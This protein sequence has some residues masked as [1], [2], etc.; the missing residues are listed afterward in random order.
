MALSLTIY[1]LVTAA[2]GRRPNESGSFDQVQSRPD[3]SLVW[4][5]ASRPKD[6][7]AVHEIIVR[8]SEKLPGS[9][10]LISGPETLA[11]GKPPNAVYLEP[12]SEMA[13]VVK[14]FLDHW[15][16]DAVVWV[17]APLRPVL[18]AEL[19]AQ[20]IPL[21]LF[22][23]GTTL[24]RSRKWKLL[25]GLTR[26]TLR[27]FGKI[28]VGDERTQDDFLRAGATATQTQVIGVL[29]RGRHAPDCNQQEWADLSGLLV[30]RPIWLAAEVTL[31]E[32][33]SI[34]SAHVQAVRRS[35]R[36]LLIIVPGMDDADALVEKITRCGLTFAIRSHDQEP[37]PETQVYVVDTTQEM[38]L[39][40][41]LATTTFIG[42]TLF[43]SENPG[44]NPFDAAAL[45]SAIIHGP[46]TS[47]HQDAFRR[48][49]R[50]QAAI[51]VP[52]SVELGKM[53]E[54]LLAPDISAALAHAAWEVCTSSAQ[55]IDGAVAQISQVITN[56]EG[57]E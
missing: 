54:R 24:D 6:S 5:L 28:L 8:L 29:E 39:W 25:P 55:V 13:S 22:D 14:P 46:V 17:E 3:G 20:N 56:Q 37:D 36:L 48:L 9:H 57:A 18:V 27:K 2:M 53:V 43:P 41:R 31:A 42:G 49:A 50:A 51:Q 4:I 10:C 30:T 44:P 1:R 34:L 11:A 38:G 23:S 26:A 33:D 21:F 35:H 47:S 45:G 12:P 19:T 52:D 40:Y 15:R 16:P 32:M 7:D